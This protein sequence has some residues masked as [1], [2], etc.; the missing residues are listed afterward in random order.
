MKINEAK[1]KKAFAKLEKK[2]KEKGKE[3]INEQ[4]PIF[5]STCKRIISHIL[6]QNEEFKMEAQVVEE[7]KSKEEKILSEE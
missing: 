3:F 6:K 7:K 5:Y 2:E 1:K 4:T